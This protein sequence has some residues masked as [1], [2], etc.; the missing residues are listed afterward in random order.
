ALFDD[1]PH[2]VFGDRCKGGVVAVKKG[3]TDIFV[4]HEQRGSRRFRITFTETKETFVRALPWDYLL[5]TQSEILCF[6]ALDIQLPIFTRSLANVDAQFSFAARLESKIEIVPH[7]ATV[8]AHD[9]IA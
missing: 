8:D 1:A 7:H 5:K 2:F 4:A 3:K 6:I 9:P